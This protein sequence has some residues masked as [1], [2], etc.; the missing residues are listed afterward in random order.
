M[1]AAWSHQ[2]RCHSGA[3]DPPSSNSDPGD[4]PWLPSSPDSFPACT[5][6]HQSH[7]EL[8]LQLPRA[9]DGMTTPCIIRL[10]QVQWWVR[11]VI[12]LECGE[13]GA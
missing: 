9:E 6:P 1:K 7:S 10:Q 8:S 12:W 3:H 11:L 13:Q 4:G 5:Q 2:T